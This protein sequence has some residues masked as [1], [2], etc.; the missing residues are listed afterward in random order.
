MR[1]G[2][3]RFAELLRREGLAVSPAELIDAAAA[4]AVTDVSDREAL[5]GTLRAVLVKRRAEGELFD[6]LFA[7]FFA[8]P[9]GAPAA[10]R[11]RRRAARPAGEPGGGERAGR[12]GAGGGRP[13]PD[14][15]P[16]PDGRPG[17]TPRRPAAAAAAGP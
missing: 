14:A 15:L 9:A 16:R 13:A 2:L 5:Q 10:G 6:R 12:G 8:A 1:R 3:S 7:G 4:L 11:R 17:V